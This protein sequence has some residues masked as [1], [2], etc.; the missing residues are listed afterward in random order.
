MGF[1][2]MMQIN[3][4]GF[5]KIHIFTLKSQKR[6]KDKKRIFKRKMYDLMLHWKDDRKGETALLIQGAGRIGKSTLVEEFARRESKRKRHS[7][8]SRLHDPI[9]VEDEDLA[10]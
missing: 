5:G 8:S 6:M 7:V 2:K 9:L 10:A 4:V 1:G 3:L